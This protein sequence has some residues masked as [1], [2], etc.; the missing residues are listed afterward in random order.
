[1]TPRGHHHG[2]DSHDPTGLSARPIHHVLCTR[3]TWDLAH[4]TV[5]ARASSLG[6]TALPPLAF[7]GICPL[8]RRCLLLLLPELPQTLCSVPCWQ[9]PVEA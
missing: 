3:G 4:I 5:S 6:P 2:R 9:P 7:C 8:Y 1:M